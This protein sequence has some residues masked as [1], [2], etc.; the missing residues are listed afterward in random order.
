MA[1][2]A[3]AYLAERFGGGLDT[4]AVPDAAFADPQVFG[5]VP[6]LT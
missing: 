4:F 6:C 5:T 2:R 1:R 3:D